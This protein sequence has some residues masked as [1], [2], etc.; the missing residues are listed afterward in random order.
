MNNDKTEAEESIKFSGKTKGKRSKLSHRRPASQKDAAGGVGNEV[1]LINDGGND[2]SAED[3]GVQLNNGHNQSNNIF[4]QVGTD[5]IGLNTMGLDSSPDGGLMQQGSPTLLSAL[6]GS[7]LRA[8]AYGHDFSTSFKD[9]D[10]GPLGDF[11]N[12]GQRFS[13]NPLGGSTEALAGEGDLGSDSL[14]SSFP[15]DVDSFLPSRMP[16]S[17]GEMSGGTRYDIGEANNVGSTGNGMGGN[18]AENSGMCRSSSFLQY[19][20]Q[21]GENNGVGGGNGNGGGQPLMSNR[22]GISY[23]CYGSGYGNGMQQSQQQQES[24]GG[25]MQ[26]GQGVHNMRSSGGARPGPGHMQQMQ[27]QMQPNGQMS[28]NGQQ[29]QG[30]LPQQARPMRY[31]MQGQQ[32]VGYVQMPYQHQPM[33]GQQI[34]G[35]VMMQ[36]PY[37]YNQMGQTGQ[38]QQQ[39]QGAGKGVGAESSAQASNVGSRQGGATKG[40][41]ESKGKG[42]KGKEHTGMQQ[43]DMG[44]AGMATMMGRPMVTMGPPG[45]YAMQPMQPMQTQQMRS[46]GTQGMMYQQHPQQ[47]GDQGLMMHPRLFSASSSVSTDGSGDALGQGPGPMGDHMMMP[48]FAMNQVLMGAGPGGNIGNGQ[49]QLGSNGN[50]GG[51]GAEEAGLAELEAIVA[52]LD[53]NTVNNIKESLYRLARAARSRGSRNGDGGVQGQGQ[54]PPAAD[55]AKSLVDKCVANLLYHKY[56][57][58]PAQGNGMLE[59]GQ[60]INTNN[61]DNNNGSGL[62]TSERTGAGLQQGGLDQSARQ[63]RSTLTRPN[64]MANV[65]QGRHGSA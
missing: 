8:S 22:A 63:Q 39:D 60:Q 9:D 65:I 43:P 59:I 24:G 47:M 10:I 25:L 7:S 57:D 32:Q 16:V 12:A 64:S 61:N 53:K 46:S 30:M 1:L 33:Q 58:T 13:L 4:N 28:F 20:L 49:M 62:I 18:G 27:M 34:Q 31:Y 52:R 35:G 48:P 14:W 51:I 29:Q 41:T 54:P 36:Q 15:V 40:K 17:Y 5:S 55:K 2:G 3:T 44:G 21:Y 38:Q 11:K 26:M 50:S 19:V 6:K 23:D 56:T 45:S 37:Q 42:S